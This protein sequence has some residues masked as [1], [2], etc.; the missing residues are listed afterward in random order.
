M[1]LLSD[2]KTMGRVWL[3]ANTVYKGAIA[4]VLII[5][6]VSVADAGLTLHLTIGGQ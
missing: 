2:A 1:K 4:A 6:A 3:I 5:T